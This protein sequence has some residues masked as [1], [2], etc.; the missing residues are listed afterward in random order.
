MCEA[1][2]D[3]MIESLILRVEIEGQQCMR[4]LSADLLAKKNPTTKE[5]T[6]F[7]THCTQI[8][9]QI[10]KLWIIQRKYSPGAL[11]CLATA[12]D[13]AEPLEAKH[14]PLFL[15]SGLSPLQAMPLLSAPNIVIAEAQLC[16]VQC[17]E[18]LEV[19]R[20]GLIAKRWLQTYKTLNSRHQHQNT[21]S[22]TLVDGQ[23]RKIDLAAATYWQVWHALEQADLRLPKDEEEVKRRKQH[24]MKGK[25]KEAQQAN[26]NS[27][28]WGVPGMGEKTC[29]TSWIW[30]AAGG[31]EGVVGEAMH[32]GVRVELSKVYTHVK[33]WWE[34][35]RLLQ[36]EMVCCL[37]TLKWQAV[38][39]D[40]C[41]MP[42]HYTG[43]IVYST[44]HVQGAMAFTARVATAMEAP[45]KATIM[46]YGWQWPTAVMHCTLPV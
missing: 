35:E 45:R 6:D 21:Q 15:P 44:T 40:Q 30:Y 26:E 31:M 12:G 3:T 27:E 41:A 42:S 13:P 23:Q 19:I 10:K 43:Q 36:E 16:D 5:L 11:Q 34:E 33:C 22:R 17:S 8:S 2:D 29:V 32:E 39:W 28:V 37:L 18:S 25:R 9:Q 46:H 1:I 20:H 38:Q 4:Q 24:T 7:I 14:A